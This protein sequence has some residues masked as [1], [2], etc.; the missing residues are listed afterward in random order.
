MVWPTTVLTELRARLKIRENGRVGRMER[1]RREIGSS[2][3]G[4]QCMTVQ[5]RSPMWVRRNIRG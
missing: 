1:A 3:A 5:G 4:R 2:R